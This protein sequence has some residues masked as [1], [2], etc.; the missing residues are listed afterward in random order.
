MNDDFKHPST[1][2]MFRS[3]GSSR[4]DTKKL[5]KTVKE[6]SK[7]NQNLSQMATVRV[8]GVHSTVTSNV[9]LKYYERYQHVRR[10]KLYLIH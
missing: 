9:M 5:S 7:F 8:V 10:L 2:P 3:A 1:V 6:I 4:V